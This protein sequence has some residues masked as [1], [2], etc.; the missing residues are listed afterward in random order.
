MEGDVEILFKRKENS[1]I[2]IYFVPLLLNW[3]AILVMIWVGM[4]PQSFWAFHFVLLSFSVTS[5]MQLQITFISRPRPSAKNPIVRNKTGHRLAAG[6]LFFFPP[7]LCCQLRGGWPKRPVGFSPS[8][9]QPLHSNELCPHPICSWGDLCPGVQR[10]AGKWET[11][12]GLPQF[13]SCF[14]TLYSKAKKVWD[15][16][17]VP[18]P[19]DLICIVISQW[20]LRL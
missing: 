8:D 1:V 18:S 11:Q 3:L 20:F 13:V 12:K 10:H 15:D 5:G 4:R 16:F 9:F 7:C 2:L 14:T 19:V 6:G 17:G